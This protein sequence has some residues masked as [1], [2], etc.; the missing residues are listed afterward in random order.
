VAGKKDKRMKRRKRGGEVK[1][2]KKRSR[3]GFYAEKK[4]V[5]G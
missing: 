2:G 3:Q 5:A 4:R 1:G